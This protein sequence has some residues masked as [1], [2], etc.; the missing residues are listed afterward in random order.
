MDRFLAQ[1]SYAYTPMYREVSDCKFTI[2]KQFVKSFTDALKTFRKVKTDASRD[3]VLVAAHE[4][5]VHL[6]TCVLHRLG[7]RRQLRNKTNDINVPHERVMRDLIRKVLYINSEMDSRFLGTHVDE[8][9]WRDVAVLLM[10]MVYP[11]EFATPDSEFMKGKHV[12]KTIDAVNIAGF[13]R[14]YASEARKLNAFGNVLVQRKPEQQPRAPTPRAPTPRL[15]AVPNS[16]G[17]TLVA[18]GGGRRRS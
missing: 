11:Y 10:E 18:H 4:A 14:W 5:R 17:F 6:V 2:A 3:T 1:T 12:R 8:R 16:N 9:M 7:K 13:K 15:V